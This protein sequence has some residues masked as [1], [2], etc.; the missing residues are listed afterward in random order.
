MSNTLCFLL[1]TIFGAGTYAQSDSSSVFYQKGLEEKNARRFREAEKNFARAYQLS[2]DKLEVVLELANALM[3]QN[4]FAEAREKYLSAEKIDN[5]NALVTENLAT[6]SFNLRKWA[7]AIKYATKTQQMKLSKP[8]NYIIGKSYFEQENYG[9]AIKFL[10][11]AAKEEPARGEI[12][13][14]VSRAYLDMSNYK[15]SAAYM[16]KAISLDTS[17]VNWVYEC[18]LIY[19]AIPDYKKS[20]YFFELAG[21][22][23]YKRSNDYLENLGNA[24]LNTA[25]YEKGIALLKEV[26]KMKPSDQELLYV[27]AQASF[28]AGKY[29][30]AIDYWDQALTLDKT[31]ARVLYMIGLSYQKKG[32]KQKGTQLCDKAIEMD[33]SLNSLREKQGGLM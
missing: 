3:A 13:Y 25:Q 24:Y 19:Y 15:Q 14:S 1:L 32:E 2:P 30:E 7:E 23:G 22:K 16:E 4:R 10:D 29:Q 27:V 8:V 33:P 26:L 18:A 21:T 28:K 31:N 17:K 20:L 12:P 11:M 6:L 5:N 9:E